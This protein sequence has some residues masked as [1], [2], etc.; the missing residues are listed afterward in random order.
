M[1]GPASALQINGAAAVHG[2]IVLFLFQ[3]LPLRLFG[4]NYPGNHTFL[5]AI[6]DDKFSS[7]GIVCV[8]VALFVSTAYPS[9]ALPEDLVRMC[10]THAS[11]MVLVIATLF[12]AF[13]FA[14]RL[15]PVPSATPLPWFSS[16]H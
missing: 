1:S 6:L 2:I 7:D 4:A 3:L 11:L 14:A 10:W 8:L 12:W 16:V 5:T 9:H 13:V 15:V